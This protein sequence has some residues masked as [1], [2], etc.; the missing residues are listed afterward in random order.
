[1][2]VWRL[3]SKR[4]AKSAFSGIGN[5][6]VGSRWVPEGLLAVYTSESIALVLCETLVHMDPRHLRDNHAVI[7]ADIPD[8]MPMERL[9]MNSLPN[10]WRSRFDDP[11]LQAIGRDWIEDAGSAV[12]AVPSVV[13]PQQ[14]NYI[15][16][17]EHPDFA[18][19][20]LGEPEVFICDPRLMP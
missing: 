6:K 16:N 2:R 14:V 3:A 12:L 15:L 20:G 17:P 10:D 19:I 8:D 5:R 9:D 11:L 18:G 4:H 13:V 7:A 1:M